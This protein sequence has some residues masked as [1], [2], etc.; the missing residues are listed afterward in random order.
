MGNAASIARQAVKSTKF[1]VKAVSTALESK[2]D[3]TKASGSKP[4]PDARSVITQ[5]LMSYGAR[6]K[7]RANETA[8]K[9]DEDMVEEISKG[10][11]LPMCTY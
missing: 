4:A 11:D 6:N 7:P 10:T 9:D 3:N 8:D 5:K 2:K 1:M